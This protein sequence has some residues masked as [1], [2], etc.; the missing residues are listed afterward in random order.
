MDVDLE[1]SFDTAVE[2][3]RRTIRKLMTL[4]LGHFDSDVYNNQQIEEELVS[5]STAVQNV[6]NVMANAR[7]D[8][9]I[10]KPIV[11]KWQSILDELESKLRG[12]IN[13]HTYKSAREAI[14]STNS[15]SNQTGSQSTLQ[16]TANAIQEAEL[17][18][19]GISI[20]GIKSLASAVNKEV[21]SQKDMLAN[22]DEKLNVNSSFLDSLVDRMA[23]FLRTKD[24]SLLRLVFYLT[25]L[26]S[27]LIFV[28]L[29][30]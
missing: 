14:S 28:L 6:S 13:R 11:D 16:A 17:A 24:P 19:L 2:N 8:S 9:R 18:E 26:S 30:I 7:V 21:Y 15:Y 3:A 10:S 29:I 12:A 5:A 23:G 25:C 20:E 1:K 27:F 22:L 4:Q